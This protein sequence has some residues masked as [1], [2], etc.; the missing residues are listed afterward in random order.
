MVVVD[1]NGEQV[2]LAVDEV[3]GEVSTV[4]KSLGPLFEETK[5][6]AGCAIMP[7]GNVALILDIRSLVSLSRTESRPWSP[8]AEQAESV[9]MQ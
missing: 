7:S 6:I 9:V 8:R 5:G 2:A 4:I 1:N 3:L